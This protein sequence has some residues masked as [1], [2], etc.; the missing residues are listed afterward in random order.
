MDFLSEN[1]DVK[2]E[3]SE[4]KDIKILAKISKDAF[5]TDVLDGILGYK[6]SNG[7]LTFSTVIDG[8]SY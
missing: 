2:I 6:N 1:K 8:G 3:R 7:G 4:E 5:N